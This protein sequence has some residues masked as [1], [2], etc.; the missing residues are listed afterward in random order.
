MLGLELGPKHKCRA[1][2]RNDNRIVESDELVEVTMIPTKVYVATLTFD[3][4]GVCLGI[5][6]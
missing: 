3:I 4:L 1:P 5:A 6:A 2:N